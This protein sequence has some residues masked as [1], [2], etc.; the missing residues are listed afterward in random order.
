MLKILTLNWNGKEKLERLYTSLMPAIQDI[1]YEWFVK[2]NASKDNSVHY[3]NSFNNNQLK[4]FEYKDNRQNFSEGCNYLF[5]EASPNDNDYIMLLNNDVIFNDIYSIKNMLSIIQDDGSVGMVGSK[6]LYTNTDMLQHAGV[7]FDPTYRT[8]MHFRAGQKE[9][10]DSSRNRLFQ[11]VTG[12]VCITKAEYFRN[13]FTNK[14]GVKGMDQNYYWAFDDVDLSL[15]IYHNM[16]KKVVYCGNT[17]IFHDESA[18]L[19]KNP[20]NKLFLNHNLKYMF[21]KW[22]GRYNIDKKEYTE[23]SRH[24]LYQA[25]K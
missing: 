19:K 23:N 5:N 21:E 13:A 18:S 6:L 9:D 17:N 11:V 22:G 12:A 16:K 24:N 15:S 1:E 3:L 4:V 25:P 10:E 8:P 2:D 14:S 7:V 20:V